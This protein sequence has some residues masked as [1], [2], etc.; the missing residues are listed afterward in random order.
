MQYLDLSVEIHLDGEDVRV[1]GDLNLRLD[2]RRGIDVIT[3]A[4]R[5]D[6]NYRSTL[7]GSLLC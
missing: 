2:V 5:I 4:R 6:S 7:A 1:F 3:A